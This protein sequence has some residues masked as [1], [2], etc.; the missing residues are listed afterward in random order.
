[1][2]NET[3]LSSDA[4]EWTYREFIR[5]DPERVARM[6]LLRKHAEY[7]SQLYR[8]RNQFRIT[9]AQLA[10]IAGLTPEIIEDL[11]ESDYDGD[12]P[13]AVARINSG[14]QRWFTDVI[15]PA[16]HMNPEEYLIHDAGAGWR[17]ASVPVS[18]I[19]PSTD[20]AD[21]RRFQIQH[22]FGLIFVMRQH[23]ANT[24]IVPAR[25]E[26]LHTGHFFFLRLRRHAACD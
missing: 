7:A 13:D 8:I 25:R 22:P 26:L 12:W 14:F 5:D 16:S 1:M 17:H 24:L 4:V 18:K 15:I 23:R 19:L 10:E 20:Y 11:E 3:G 2:N 6:K 9:R 21:F